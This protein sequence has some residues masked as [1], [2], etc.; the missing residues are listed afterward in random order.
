MRA[1]ESRSRATTQGEVIE[2]TMM[3]N[4]PS[5]WLNDY[6]LGGPS[7]SPG[8]FEYSGWRGPGR[9]KRAEAI[10]RSQLAR[11][12]A[13][14]CPLGWD[15]SADMYCARGSDGIGALAYLHIYIN[16]CETGFSTLPGVSFWDAP[17]EDKRV[18]GLRVYIDQVVGRRPEIGESWRALGS[19]ATPCVHALIDHLPTHV[20]EVIAFFKRH[21]ESGARVLNDT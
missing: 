14:L 20:D 21:P 4:S 12:A 18:Y 10:I 6:P 15:I 7:K 9:S 11:L 2:L 13:A 19:S 3:E 5:R 17:D 8:S 16:G 1:H